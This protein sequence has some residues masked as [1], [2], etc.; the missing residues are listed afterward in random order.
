[1]DHPIIECFLS[2]SIV[3][4]HDLGGHRETS[5]TAENGV[6]WLRDLLVDEIPSARILTYG[7]DANIRGKELTRM[8]YDHAETF[9]AKLVLFRKK[10]SVCK[11]HNFADNIRLHWNCVRRKK[12]QLYLWP[13][14]WAE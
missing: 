3:A 6:L 13:I 5:W 1:V 11:S 10:T 14:V 9:I 12:D 7:Y 4:I 2:Y 8:L